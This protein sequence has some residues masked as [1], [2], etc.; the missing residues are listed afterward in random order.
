MPDDSAPAISESETSGLPKPKVLAR[1][2]LEYKPPYDVT[3]TIERMIDSVPAKYLV[4]LSEVVLTNSTGLARKRRRSVTKSRKK[5]VRTRTA[6]GMYHP[7]W[8]GK[9]P[10]IEIFVDNTLDR[11]DG[12][13]LKIPLFRE[14]ELSNVLF[15][16]I[17][18]HIHYEVRPEYREKEDVADVWKVR[19][20]RN[21]W[22]NRSMFL[23]VFFRLLRLFIGPIIDWLYFKVMK[24]QRQ[25][26]RI[27]QA[28]FEETF[29]R[30]VRRRR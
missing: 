22:R 12:F 5:K 27:S 30:K 29:R 18:H 3:P 19:L 11:I 6:L 21:Y 15:H 20:D 4:G 14:L 23:G 16:E 13:L 17:G 24:S 28:E 7:G 9:R 1:Y 10:W 25:K 8:K 2:S 26:G